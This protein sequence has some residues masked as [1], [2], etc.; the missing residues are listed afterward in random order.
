MAGVAHPGGQGQ[1]VC[2]SDPR[3]F[4]CWCRRS[5]V[6][7]GVVLGSRN[8]KQQVGK[9]RCLYYLQTALSLL[10]T[11]NSK[12]TQPRWPKFG[13]LRIQIQ[14]Q[15]QELVAA[16]E[17]PVGV[18]KHIGAHKAVKGA[19]ERLPK[20]GKLGGGAH[21]NEARRRGGHGASQGGGAARRG[22]APGEGDARHGGRQGPRQGP[23][24]P[25]LDPLF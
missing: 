15:V 7:M 14:I 3:V 8:G 17:A 1:L 20:F 10:L 19:G 9:Q 2:R 11:A 16:E 23:E 5:I 6:P 12:R 24:R 18:D 25:G 21:S 4:F 22:A 13:R